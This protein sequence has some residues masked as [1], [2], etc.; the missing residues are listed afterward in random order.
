MKFKRKFHYLICKL[1]KSLYKLRHID[2]MKVTAY[3]AFQVFAFV[4]VAVDRTLQ[5]Y[6]GKHQSF[7]LM[8]M[9]IW[10]LFT[11]YV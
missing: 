6:D 7:N 3:L 8:I 1:K 9:Y 2:I 10:F 5:S 4:S 11:F